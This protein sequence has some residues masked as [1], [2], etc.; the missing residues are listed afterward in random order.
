VHEQW[1]DLID[2]MEEAYANRLIYDSGYAREHGLFTEDPALARRTDPSTSHEAAKSVDPT[3]LETRIYRCLQLLRGGA[4]ASELVDLTGLN[5]NTL[6]P[7]LA[8]LRRKNL[9]RDS[10][11]RRKGPSGRSQI[12][13]EANG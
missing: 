7:R 13:W 2:A 9:I 6:S 10:G 11:K 1:L 12:V 5:W 8:P 4:T 3:P